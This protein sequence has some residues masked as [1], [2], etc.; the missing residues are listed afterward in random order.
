MSNRKITAKELIDD[1]RK[2]LDDS[3]LIEKY[4]VSSQAL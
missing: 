4:K 2:G 1:I 3:A